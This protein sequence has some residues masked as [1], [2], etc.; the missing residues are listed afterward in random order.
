MAAA[1]P[2]RKPWWRRLWHASLRAVRAVAL[3]EDTPHRIAL[4]SACGIFASVLP[5]LGQT[6]VGMLLARALRGSVLASL[7]WSWISNPLTTL[8]IW[9][10][11]YRLGC[12]LLPGSPALGW[13]EVTDRFRL[14]GEAGWREVLD[15]GA[16]LL[17][18]VFWPLLLGSVVLGAAAGAVGYRLMRQ[19]VLRVQA[20]RARRAAAWAAGR[21]QDA[22]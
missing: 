15:H 10:A 22:V 16:E 1:P 2:T 12:I 21:P 8:P 14:F 18:E 13:D 3:L 9:F 7:P 11:C 6:F 17:G 4:G 20:R 19:L 5:T